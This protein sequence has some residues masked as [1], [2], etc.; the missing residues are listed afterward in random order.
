M[1]RSTLVVMAGVLSVSL[2][3][4]SGAM[5]QTTKKATCDP[6]DPRACLLPWPSNHFTR[7]ADTETNRQ[8]R[9]PAGGMPANAS[10]KRLSVKPYMLSDG[11]SPSGPILTHVPGVDLAR[12]RAV[13][14][15][16]LR[17]YSDPGAPIVLIDVVT[18]KRQLIWAELD[19]GASKSSQ[20]LL[21]IHPAKNLVE[22]RRYIVALRNLRRSNG[23]V[24]KPT[25]AF[26]RLRASKRP[27]SRY[28]GIFRV[29]NKAGIRRSSLYRAWDFTVAS[30]R[31]ITE[32]ATSIRDGGFSALGDSNLFDRIPK[33]KAPGFSID[34]VQEMAVCGGD[35]CQA[36]E[37]D[38]I[39]R[40]VTGTMTVACYL[41]RKGCPRGSK[42]RFKKRVGRFGFAFIPVR[43][44]GNTMKTKFVCIIPRTAFGV[45]A[46]ASLFGH[47][48][49]GS[50]EEVMAPAVQTM[51]RE[52]NVV[53]CATRQTGMADEDRSYFESLL[54]NLNRLPAFADRQQQA[55]LNTLM[56]GRLMIG[57]K[58]LT[59]HAAFKAPSG[60]A[61]FDKSRLYYEGVGQGGNFGAAVVALSPDVQRGILVAAGMRYSMI[62]PRST[63]YEPFY[64]I[65]AKAYPDRLQQMQALALAQGL[66]DRAE[67]A[68]YAAHMTGDPPPN[69]LIHDVL[70]QNTVG[71]HQ[72]PQVAAE[73]MVRSADM[74]ARKPVFDNDRYRDKIP[75][76]NVSPAPRLDLES[77]IVMWDSGPIR[78]ALG[79]DLPPVENV[80]PVSGADPHSLLAASSA[81][82]VQKAEFMS[83]TGRILDV[84]PQNRACRLESWPY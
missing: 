17:A 65:F 57:A 37:S 8:V 74:T 68:G 24:L 11:F 4:A 54:K 59:E 36:G 79:V 35:G 10:K 82:R 5:A 38:D 13:P 20:R 9:L 66:W 56:L 51:A 7:T 67:A 28:A 69:T 64:S 32:R 60:A 81:A 22:G 26:A 31:N 83:P 61:L 80:P 71:D 63:A 1:S 78:G 25:R 3:M 42:F 40:R 16:D 62:L 39:A 33:G 34:A 27:G 50:P 18:R 58:G 2:G 12:S 30:P 21:M 76:Y 45:P 14:V 53:Y 46:R 55:M 72:T 49:L 48:V 44:K 73:A 6:V 52:H 84:C 41:D 15:T 75:Y 77:S 19:A 70:M 29:L 43:T 47:D 23:A